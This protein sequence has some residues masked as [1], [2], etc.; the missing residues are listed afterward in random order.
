MAVYL[1]LRFRDINRTCWK[2]IVSVL[3]AHY[4]PYSVSMLF[5]AST[6][7]TK[8][9]GRAQTTLTG[10]ASLNKYAQ[11]ICLS[12]IG[13]GPTHGPLFTQP[14]CTKRPSNADTERHPTMILSYSLT[15]PNISTRLT[16]CL[17]WP[18]LPTKYVIEEASA[19]MLL[20]SR[21]D[22]Y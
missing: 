4:A 15:D 21:R 6:G 18:R 9:V 5:M 7:Q 17:S 20:P 1:D 22:Q 16:P 12:H 3:V 19:N 13:E 2:A 10:R 11:T 14:T 8:V